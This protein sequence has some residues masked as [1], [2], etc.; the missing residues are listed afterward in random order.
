LDNQT[1]HKAIQI[2][3]HLLLKNYSKL[4]K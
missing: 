2:L 4:M 3:H 1:L